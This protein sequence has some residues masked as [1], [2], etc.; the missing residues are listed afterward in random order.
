MKKFN[1]IEEKIV[2][3]ERSALDRWAKGDPSGCL[4]IS[5]D[6]VTYFDPFIKKRI[7]G[8]EALM[9]YYEELRGKIKI[10]HYEILNPQVKINGNIVLLNYNYISR[11]GNDQSAWNCSEIYKLFDQEWKII[12]THW[13]ITATTTI[14]SK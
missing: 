8:K 10:D 11:T 5:A 4:E 3:L 1:S 12:H 6:E 9:S 2:G 13:S 7:D 14:T